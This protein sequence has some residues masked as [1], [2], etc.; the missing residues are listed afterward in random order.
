MN[1]TLKSRSL[2]KNVE[3]AVIAFATVVVAGTCIY[4]DGFE[5]FEAFVALHDAWQ[6]DEIFVVLMFGGIASVILLFRRARDLRLEIRRREA[7][8]ERAHSLARHD[9]LTGLPNRRVLAEDLAWAIATVADRRA[10]CAVFLIDLDLFKPINDVHGHVAGDAVLIEAAERITEIVG[11]A[12]T[13]ARMGGDEFACVISYQAGSD[14]PARLASQI[15][16]ALKEP[17]LLKGIRMQIGCTI[18]IARAPTDGVTASALLHGADLAMYKGKREGRGVY[19]FFDEEMDIQMRE[20]AALEE[21][22]RLAVSAGEIIPY[23]QPVMDLADGRI[24][25]F[26]ALARWTHPTKGPIAP[27]RFIPIAE[28][29]GIIDEIT[30]AMLRVSCVAAR[31]W[32]APLSL[33]VNVSPLQLKDPWLASR[34]LAILTETGIAPGR[35]IVEVTENAVI[36]DMPRAREV[37]GSL[38]NAGVRIALDDFG[39]GYSSLYHLRQLRFDQLKIDRSFV[40]SMDSPE[41]AKIV[42]AVTGLGKSLGMPVTAEGV[43]TKAEADALRELGCEHAQG[44]LFGKPL[45]AADT[46]AFLDEDSASRVS[47]LRSA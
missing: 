23:F 7:S 20:R 41:S 26:E 2:V 6:L 21:D 27:D 15:L 34:L 47:R 38:Q 3:L 30:Y 16:R 25:G 37:F 44:F 46:I 13:V 33:S 5:W 11:I 4:F 14:L 36:D 24:L 40:H 32:P 10:E 9:P 43:E 12:G 31:D 28:D 35:L 45:N 17:M 8:E 19:H 42:S 29:L 22:L 39:K 18:G 1:R